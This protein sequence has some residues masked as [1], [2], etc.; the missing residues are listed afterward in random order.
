MRS[1]RL[2]WRSPKRDCSSQISC[3][4]SEKRRGTA[5]VASSCTVTR[6]AARRWASAAGMS[7]ACR[8]I[9]VRQ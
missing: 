9:S 6:S 2:R 8:V 4:G 3:I 1:T 5:I 7:C